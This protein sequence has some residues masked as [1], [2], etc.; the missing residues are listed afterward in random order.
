MAT[1]I[2]KLATTARWTG[3]V[4]SVT[5]Y[6]TDVVS[7]NKQTRELVLCH[8]GW[9]TN[10]TKKRINQAMGVLALPVSV[11]QKDM[12]WYIAIGDQSYFW[13]HRNM[14]VKWEDDSVTVTGLKLT[15]L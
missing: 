1:G 6:D 14:L 3:D 2:G 7:W 12:Q 10:T 9:M 8:G 4:F 15:W 5:L 13:T 11:Y